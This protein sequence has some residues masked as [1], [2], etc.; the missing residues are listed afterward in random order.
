MSIKI[1]ISRKSKSN[2]GHAGKERNQAKDLTGRANPHHLGRKGRNSS[3]K[4]SCKRLLSTYLR[5]PLSVALVTWY[6]LQESHQQNTT[7]SLELL[8]WKTCIP[9]CSPQALWLGL[10]P[11]S[12]DSL[13]TVQVSVWAS[14]RREAADPL[15][16]TVSPGYKVLPQSASMQD[17][18]LEISWYW[19]ALSRNEQ[20]KELDMYKFLTHHLP[21]T[22]KYPKL[23][24]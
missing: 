16:P 5:D 2:G 17:D 15:H 24:L 18:T 4:H 19:I 10:S 11:E 21:P 6:H 9:H 23:F 12:S 13:P 22:P 7:A 8:L 1:F 3:S 14:E 20:R